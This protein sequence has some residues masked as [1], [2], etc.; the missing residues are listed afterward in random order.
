M[1]LPVLPTCNTCLAWI[2]TENGLGECHRDPTI[3]AKE[4]RNFCASHPEWPLYVRRVSESRFQLNSSVAPGQEL[5][6]GYDCPC[7][8]IGPRRDPGR[9]EVVRPDGGHLNFRKDCEVCLGTG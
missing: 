8:Q 2:A 1:N 9:L 3:I 7:V 4:S 5:L 6:Y